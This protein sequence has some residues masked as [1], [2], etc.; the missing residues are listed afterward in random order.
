MTTTAQT[1]TALPQ[2][3]A[4]MDQPRMAAYRE[5]LEFYNGRQWPARP[6]RRE[7]QLTF[8]YARVLVDKLTS[9]LMSGITLDVEPADDSPE[10]RERARRAESDLRAVYDAN[11]LESL[12]FETELDAAILGDGCY[13]V[14]WDAEEQRVR[15]T[16]PDAQGLYAWWAGD[17]VSRVWRVASRYRLPSEEAAALY[18]VSP[19]RFGPSTGSGSSGSAHAREVTVVEA[20]TADSFELWLDNEVVERRAN[21]CGFIPFVIFPNLRQPKQFW[22]ASDIPPLIEPSRELNRAM[23]QLSTILELSGN[24]IAVL[25]NV[26]ESQDIAVQ[27]GA[28]WEIPERARAYLLDLLQGGGVNLHADYI[29][30]L[31]RTLHDVSEAPRTAFGD[32]RQGLSGVALEMELHPLLQKVRRKRLVRSAVYRRRAQMALRLLERH[33]GARYGDV[34]VKVTWGP[35]LP[36]DRGRLVSDEE[37]LVRAGLHSRRTAMSALGVEDP[38]GELARVREEGGAGVGG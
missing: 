8:N 34:R 1:Q 20:W 36:Q 30:L 11:A 37:A 18:G 23:S 35:V 5:N 14:T 13:K 19:N 6:R 9:Y 2:Q 24:P 21:P 27:P 28:V 12:D 3:V 31:Y 10:G 33:T 29:D 38:E 25:E 15:V 22:G 17:D 4:R 7:R 32:N 16:A 26:E